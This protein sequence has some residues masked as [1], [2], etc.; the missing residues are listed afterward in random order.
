MS[1]TIIVGLQWGDE[2]KGK[3]VDYLTE[4]SDVVARAQGG[5][6][7]G[8][9]VINNDTKYILHL[10]PSGILWPDK[11]CVIGNGVVIDPI[12]LLAEI[13]KLRGQGVNIT[14]ENLLISDRAH[15][16]LPYHQ[17]LDKARETRR[18]E[19]AIGTTGRGIGPT[20]ADKIERQGLRITDL[21]DTSKLAAE[22]EWRAALHN[23]ELEV[24]GYEKVNVAEV[25]EKITAAAIR[26]QPH[27]TNTVVYLNHALDNGM[28]I[29]FEG[30][31]GSYLDIDHGTYPFV[32][33]SNTTAGGACT[34]S[35]VSPRKIDC[36]VGVAKAYTTRVGGGP[37][38]TESQEISD[39]L[40]GMG[41]EY[42]A[43]TGR[44]RRCGWLDLVLIHHAV[45]INGCDQ[46]AITNLDGLDT[47]PTIRI[48]TAYELDGQIINHPPSTIAE[49]ERCKPIYEEH[50]GW[51]EDLSGKT[52]YADLPDKAKAYL[53]RLGEL[54]GAPVT[55][56]GIGPSRDQ[57]LVVS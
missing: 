35:G 32:T 57:T 22:I 9:T 20:Y 17:S 10:I 23:Q 54:A 28:K 50:E 5:S 37:F 51:L 6:N 52:D 15:L 45:M 16:T 31:Q 55:L 24:A 18:G 44:E 46:L 27:I 26:L 8:H 14:P 1:N 3:I 13:D 36:V 56:L 47:L 39:M 43:T 42:G 7:A 53:A 48:C 2:G 4:R 30:A 19:N 41:R 25:V 40:H 12:G 33:S 38:I 49:I 34:G 11:I 29:L 21:R